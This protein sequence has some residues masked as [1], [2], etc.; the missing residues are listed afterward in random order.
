MLLGGLGSM[1][2]AAA[3][4][5]WHGGWEVFSVPRLSGWEPFFGAKS[6][7]FKSFIFPK[8]NGAEL[9]NHFGFDK[10]LE[11][12]EIML[13]FSSW[14][15]V[16][17]FRLNLESSSVEVSVGFTSAWVVFSKA[18]RL[19]EIPGPVGGKRTTSHWPDEQEAE[20]NAALG[21]FFLL[22]A[23]QVASCF[24]CFMC[25]IVG[26]LL[27]FATSVGSAPFKIPLPEWGFFCQKRKHN[28]HEN[29]GCRILAPLTTV[30]NL[31]FR[32]L[33]VGLGCEVSCI[34]AA[35]KTKKT[36]VYHRSWHIVMSWGSKVTVGE[37][38]L[39]LSIVNGRGLMIFCLLA[40]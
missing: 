29:W 20:T 38:A 11:W 13:F 32:R 28:F 30:G 6:F 18:H 22:V 14:N 9:L 31:P 7:R 10:M 3:Q 15:F 5:C 17:D 2:F 26:Y 37:M 35:K 39:S 24:M 8:K 1:A 21:K 12:F 25:G 23:G 33:C 19:G 34:E 40:V 36:M 27:I 4:R 16:F